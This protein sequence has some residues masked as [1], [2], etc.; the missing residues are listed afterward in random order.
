MKVLIIGGTQSEDAYSQVKGL[1]QAGYN[2]KFLFLSNGANSAAEFP[3]KVGEGNA[4]AARAC[5]DSVL[6]SRAREV[7]LA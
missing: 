2:P 1:V 5:F 6:T 3:G 4:A 7:S